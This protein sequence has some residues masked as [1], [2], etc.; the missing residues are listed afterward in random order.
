VLFACTL[1]VAHN[2]RAE[3]QSLE[4]IQVQSICSQQPRL[5]I[6]R[7]YLHQSETTSHCE[8]GT[9]DKKI[10][11]LS[12]K[13]KKNFSF[14]S[15]RIV[16]GQCLRRQ[17]TVT[18]SAF[19]MHELGKS[20]NRSIF[21][22]LFTLSC[23]QTTTQWCLLPTAMGV[24]ISMMAK[25]LRQPRLISLKSSYQELTVLA[26]SA[27]VCTRTASHLSAAAKTLWLSFGTFTSF[28]VQAVCQQ[29]TL[30]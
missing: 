18:K 6:W 7:K 27:F 11:P 9:H 19:G 1:R 21:H 29:T 28:W 12:K 8:F 24:S 23:G 17:T 15:F 3:S 25:Y 10:L 26:V 30:E 20:T 5:A 4:H 14:A 22:G 16:T 2:L 13:Q